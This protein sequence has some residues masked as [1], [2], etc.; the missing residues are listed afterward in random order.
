MA[1]DAAADDVKRN[2]ERTLHAAE[3]VAQDAGDELTDR[4]ADAGFAVLGGGAY[5]V[6]TTVSAT[7]RAVELPGDVAHVIVELPD[8][9][10]D[11]FDDLTR[12]GWRVANRIDRRVDVKTVTTQAN[13]TKGVT[14]S[15]VRGVARTARRAG[16]AA[17]DAADAVADTNSRR[18]TRYE[19]R[20]VDELHD[21]AHRAQHRGPVVDEQG[22]AHPG[23]AAQRLRIVPVSRP[24]RR[25]RPLVATTGGRRRAVCCTRT[26]CDT[27]GMAERLPRLPPQPEDVPWPVG[28]WPT[29]PLEDDVRADRLEAQLEVAADP[30]QV[31]LTRRCS[32]STGGGWSSSATPAP[33]S[34]TARRSPSTPRPCCRP[35][36]WPSRCC[37]P[38]WACWWA[39]APCGSRTGWWTWPPGPCPA[40]SI[41]PTT[42]TGDHRRA[43]A[44]PPPGL[45]WSRADRPTGTVTW[46]TCSTGTAATTWP[47]SWPPSRW[48]T[49][50]LDRGV[51]LLERH[52][53]PAVGGGA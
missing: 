31:G 2:A 19:D 26:R 45:A 25:R 23:A 30:N 27:A 50:R 10:R 33:S 16:D 51:R 3:D 47:A 40:G 44:A 13:R 36:R 11:G 39:M 34:A 18:G 5:A 22:R 48:C 53:Q 17:E 8:R 32:S 21:L 42:A 14:R 6:E 28:D 49:Y 52:L 41:G 1:A 37:T 12:A 20:T 4:L 38:P 43:P 15:A 29:G 35:G 46:S 7:R 24:D 9:V